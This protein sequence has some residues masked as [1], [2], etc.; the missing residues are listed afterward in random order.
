M[1][2]SFF[3]YIYGDHRDLHI[4]THSFPTGRSSDLSM[5][6]AWLPSPTARISASYRAAIMRPLSGSSVR[7]PLTPARSST[8]RGGC[9]AAIAGRSEEH[10]SELQS[11]M[12][13]SYAVFRLTTKTISDLRT[14]CLRHE[15]R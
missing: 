14:P 5:A 15:G 9:L 2:V 13:S 7:K 8:W 4:R 11:L 12:R 6:W 3:G 10:T 1:F